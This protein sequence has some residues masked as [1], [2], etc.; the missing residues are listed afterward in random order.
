[1]FY[2]VCQFWRVINVLHGDGDGK[3][4]QSRTGDV[5]EIIHIPQAAAPP[6]LYLTGEERLLVLYADRQGQLRALLKAPWLQKEEEPLH[7]P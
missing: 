4:Q 5:S 6:L 2:S 1:M 7:S 3:A